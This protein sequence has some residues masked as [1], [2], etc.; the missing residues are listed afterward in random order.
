MVKNYKDY[1]I[2]KLIRANNKAGC[3]QLIENYGPS[4]YGIIY[5]IVK[6]EEIADQIL[7]ETVCEFSTQ[8]KNN[9]VNILF[10]FTQL[11]QIARGFASAYKPK[12]ATLKPIHLN[13]IL[14]LI[15]NKGLSVLATAKVMNLTLAE[16]A[17]GL[18]SQLKQLNNN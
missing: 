9:N 6:D 2:I 10:L 1:H 16:V 5:R 7:K 18:R 12:T 14:D 11:M 8:I 4:I 17:L 15:F 13:N 3:K